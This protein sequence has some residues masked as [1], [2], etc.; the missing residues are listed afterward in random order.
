MPVRGT[1]VARHS[2]EVIIREQNNQE[3]ERIWCAWADCD[4][5]AHSNH[6]LV[7]NEAK[8]GFPPQICRYAFCSDNCRTYFAR[9]HIPGQYGKLPAGHRSRYM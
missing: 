8:P 4:N 9:S 6:Q 7:I 5:H 2:R 1:S 3:G